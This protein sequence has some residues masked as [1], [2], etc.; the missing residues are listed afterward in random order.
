MFLSWETKKNGIKVNVSIKK[1][2]LTNF[3][4]KL[5]FFTLMTTFMFA[6]PTFYCGT[7]VLLGMSLAQTVNYKNNMS[8]SE[9]R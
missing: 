7:T 1:K 9:P 5:H 8:S 6:C 2:H 4:Y 3:S